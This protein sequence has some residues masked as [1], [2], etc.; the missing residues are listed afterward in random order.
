M[1]DNIVNVSIS[2]N[3]N[4]NVTQQMKDKIKI[5]FPEI[6]EEYQ[7]D[8]EGLAITAFFAAMDSLARIPDQKIWGG[9]IE[10]IKF[11]FRI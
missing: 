9:S 7:H 3:A 5:V 11:G 10:D 1:S 4:V 6:Y 8:D 2:L